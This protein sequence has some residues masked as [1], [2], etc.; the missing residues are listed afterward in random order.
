M[1][2]EFAA[3]AARAALLCG[4]AAVA[5]PV[6]AQAQSSSQN[7]AQ[8]VEEIVVTGSRIARANLVAATPV[9]V[10][11][12]QQ[13]AYQAATNAFEVIAQLPTS[14][15][16]LSTTSSNFTVAAAGVNMVSLR[17]LGRART[18]VLVNGRRHVGGLEGEAA[19][20]LNSI[21]SEFIER[22]EVITGGAS[23]VYGSEAMSGV[24]NIILKRNFEGVSANFQSGISSRDD[25]R[26]HYA[27][28]TV[29]GNFD[30]GRGNAMLNLTYEKQGT[31]RSINRDLS[32]TD[33]NRSAVTGAVTRGPNAYSPFG[34]F[35]RFYLRDSASGTSFAVVD[36]QLVPFSTAAHGYDRNPDRLIQTP[37][38][39]YLLSGAARYEIIPE[40]EW[41][42]EGTYARTDV[43]R[44]LEP[45]AFG[46]N[47][48]IGIGPSAPILTIPV[49][50]P[51]MPAALRQQAQAAGATR[52]TF[53]RRFNE[54]GN[55][56]G[57]IRRNTLRFATGFTGDVMDWKYE[58]YFQ[59]G[60]TRYVQ[61]DEGVFNVLNMQN[62]LN[63]EIGPDG[64]PRCVDATA[65]AQGCVPINVFGRNTVTRE[66]LAYVQ[67]NSVSNS[68][69]SQKVAALNIT[70]DLFALPAGDVGFAAG[71]EY[72]EE[73]SL[74]IPDPLAAAGISSGNASARVQGEFDV[75][76]VYAE[77]IVPLLADLPFAKSVGIEGAV[78]YTDYSTIGGLW[79]WKAGGEWAPIEDIRFRSVYATAIRAPN[80]GELFTPPRQTFSSITDTCNGVTATSTRAQDARCR[81]DPG[82]AEAI[83]RNGSFS[84]TPQQQLSVPGFNT[85]NPDLKQESARTWTIG[86][87]M[88]PTFID[89]LS[90]SVDYYQIK[91]KDGITG[92]S[93]NTAIRECYLTGNPIYC[94]TFTRAGANGAT[95]GLIVESNL[96]QQNL[97][98]IRTSGVDAQLD[99]SIDTERV[100]LGDG[101]LS[102]N[103][104]ATYLFSYESVAFPGAATTIDVGE[105]G[106]NRFRI[107][108][109]TT[110]TT[111]PF[112]ASWRLRYIGPG[113]IDNDNRFTGSRL[114]DIVYHDLQVRYDATEWLELYTGVNNVMDVDPPLIGN[115]LPGSS[116]GVETN[117]NVYDVIGRYFYAGFNVKF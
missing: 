68:S 63:A 83:R 39:R 69:Q 36:G 26:E 86:A 30:S 37:T 73:D 66:A 52:I 48:S 1:W 81:Q 84:L 76:E 103:A 62:A 43:D 75:R 96:R 61:N 77:T 7:T 94:N 5:L 115:P 49:T 85:G 95:P 27:T 87:V 101:K 2:N 41:F 19:V 109:R 112:S 60:E 71:V 42:L 47:T 117:A 12:A 44:S 80:I 111:G 24:V 65:R 67:T 58:T 82:I 93:R 55:R 92:I 74:F 4:A 110:Y 108:T 6:A 23:A 113:E 50:N 54:L 29:G 25:G 15:S 11:D 59:Y 33:L 31:V 35:G 105:V 20:D 34:P 40:M 21:P 106:Y 8:K 51:F 46:S 90:L 72:R 102:F 16:S 3:R 99:Y 100:G 70:R 57:D 78:R 22:I 38:E 64:R 14:I 89:D 79:S 28:A 98:E 9:A 116:T 91:I 53:D 18:L 56:V 88:V 13:I 114:P 45:I 17:N 107:N 97:A 104:I 32:R 10:V